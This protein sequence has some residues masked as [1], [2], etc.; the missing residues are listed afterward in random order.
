MAF[1]PRQR[2]LQEE[3][4]RPLTRKD[5]STQLSQR[6][7]LAYARVAGISHPAEM[8][9][10]LWRGML[11]RSGLPHGARCFPR[12]RGND[13]LT[14]AAASSGQGHVRAAR[15]LPTPCRREDSLHV[16]QPRIDSA[17]W[18]LKSTSGK[19]R[20]GR[21]CTKRPSTLSVRGHA[22]GRWPRFESWQGGL[23]SHG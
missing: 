6:H 12:R 8:P 20:P 22:I 5:R 17:G 4:L 10:A 9:E 21:A 1:L 13:T 14:L 2:L 11:A 16:S 3:D 19:T 18:R 15:G 7:G 23:Q